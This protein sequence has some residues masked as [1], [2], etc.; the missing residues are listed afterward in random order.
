MKME[1][2]VDK[3]VGGVDVLSHRVDKLEKAFTSHVAGA[4]GSKKLELCYNVQLPPYEHLEVWSHSPLHSTKSE[5]LYPHNPSQYKMPGRRERDG[6]DTAEEE[7]EEEEEVGDPGSLRK[8]LIPVNHT[9]GAARLL[10]VQPIA[11][12]ARGIITYDDIKNEN[13]PMIQEEREY[14]DYLEERASINRQAMRRILWQTTGLRVPPATL[15]QMSLPQSG[16]NGVS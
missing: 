1:S 3:I 12:L 11:E 15:T 14:S 7:E 5:T 9:T 13:Y 8:P 16:R 6:H 10:L 2:L 4:E